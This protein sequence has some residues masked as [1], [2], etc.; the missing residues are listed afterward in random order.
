[1]PR[2]AKKPRAAS[3]WSAARGSAIWWRASGTCSR[4]SG[5]SLRKLRQVGLVDEV[6]EHV[7]HVVVRELPEDERHRLALLVDLERI[8]VSRNAQVVAARENAG[9]SRRIPTAR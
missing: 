2:P 1:M 6:A 5:E 7:A 4:A 8:G 9:A 3:R